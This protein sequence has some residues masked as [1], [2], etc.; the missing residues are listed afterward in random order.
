MRHDEA[1]QRTAQSHHEYVVSLLAGHDAARRQW[2]EALAGLRDAVMARSSVE[3][4]RGTVEQSARDFAVWRGELEQRQDAALR[5][6]DAQLQIK[7]SQ[8]KGNC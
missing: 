2:E 5:E 6:R 1:Q 4:V 8:I 3:S 7:E